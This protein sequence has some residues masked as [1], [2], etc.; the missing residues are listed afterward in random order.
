MSTQKNLT[1]LC[2]AAVFTLGLAA[3][4][5]GSD[6]MAP[7]T[8]DGVKMGATVNAG[9]H[10]LADDLADAFDDADPSAAMYLGREFAQGD[11]ITVAGLD[12]TC[13]AGPCQ[14]DVND[15]GTITTTGTIM[16][17]AAMVPPPPDPAIAQRADIKTKIAAAQTAVN[18]VDEESTDAEVTAAD[19]AI[20]AAKRA[21]AGAA[22]VPAAE[23]AANTG[24]IG[25]LETQ[26]AGAK[27]ARR[28]A[29]NEKK[30]DD[31]KA[32]SAKAKALKKAIMMGAATPRTAGSP[33]MT[34]AFGTDGGDDDVPAIALKAGGAAGSLG[35]WMGMNYAGMSGT[36][37][38]KVTAKSMV[39]S[40]M[41]AAKSH[42]FDVEAGEDIHGL[43]RADTA[44]DGDYTLGTGTD[45]AAVD[46]AAST[47]IG[48]FPAT[49][50]HDYDNMDTVSGTYMGA[51]GTYT[52]VVAAGCMAAAAGASGTDLTAGWTFTPDAGAM[53]QM[54]DSQYLYFGWWVRED[55]DG[56]THAGVLYGEM[57]PTGGTSALVTETVINSAALVGKATYMGKAAGKFAI[58]DALRP[59]GDDAGHFT[60]DAELMADF[61]ATGSTLS[62]TI[63]GFML[64]DGSADAGWSV[65]LQ[66]TMF[67][68]ADDK[69][70]TDAVDT[71]ADRTVWSIGD[72]MGA[73]SGKWE[74]QMFDEKTND[75]NNVPT[76]VVGSF[77]STIGTTHEMVGA[78]GAAKQ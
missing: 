6:R 43:D 66:K 16:V 35:S 67:V 52:C 1:T 33:T 45:A 46:P 25:A 9:T 4:S 17:A 22:D 49:G 78:F 42:R 14:V 13:S 60:A 63:E 2:A 74:A 39:Y 31:M 64:N 29:M 72:E 48:G 18:A 26:L 7:L 3:C 41:D 5:S 40:N 71:T 70:M 47:Q 34:P 76:S 37:D 53:L 58:S 10:T 61:M 36:G 73:A 30:A 75:G 19:N 23:K 8:L 65:A 28:T 77:M 21:V 50:T 51:P 32:M 59:G 54:K 20:A 38:A 68:D 62:G 44:A 57:M 11:K 12:I 55:K 15:N 27:S 56:P 24:T 69:F